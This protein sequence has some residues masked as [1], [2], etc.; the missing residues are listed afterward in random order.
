MNKK[1]SFEDIK[2]SPVVII[3]L[4]SLICVAVICVTVFFAKDI[5]TMKSELKEVRTKYEANLVQQE[6][7]EDLRDKANTMSIEK[8]MID[9]KLPP[10]EDVYLLME[11]MYDIFDGYSLT[12]NNFAVPVI[13]TSF[14]T[15]T[16]MEFTVTGTYSN[17]T[18][19]CRYFTDSEQLYRFE[20]FSLAD[21]VQ[22]DA[23]LKQA[24]I[25]L[26]KLSK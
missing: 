1:I 25:T 19:F 2:N 17:I 20:A 13:S 5:W 8:D 23:H 15:E 16:T 4:L 26:V 3:V 24:T 12:V 22:S 7:L 14:T 9:K 6:Y 18:A 11:Q 10:T 21:S